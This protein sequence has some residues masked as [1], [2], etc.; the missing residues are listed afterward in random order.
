M[1]EKTYEWCPHC[2][3]EV[4][5]DATL[6]VQ[7]C[8]NCGMHI[9]VCSMC[10]ACDANDGKNY[11][12][13][14]CLCY[15][16]DKADKEEGLVPKPKNAELMTKRYR[17]WSQHW[18]DIEVEGHSEEECEELAKAR[19]DEGDYDS[20]EHWEDTDMEDITD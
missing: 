16:A 20:E 10:R 18:V 14:C 5:L 4:E 19:Y 13:N 6:G 15:E 11:C 3:T 9:V 2:D 17:F 1:E 12:S 8:P 7:I